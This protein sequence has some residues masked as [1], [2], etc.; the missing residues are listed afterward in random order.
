MK[1]LTIPSP[2]P[3]TRRST[4]TGRCLDCKNAQYRRDAAKVRAKAQAKRAVRTEADAQRERELRHERWIKYEKA[5]SPDQAQRRRIAARAEA[6]RLF[7]EYN[8]N[9]S[10]T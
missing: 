1:K 4:S 6:R 8:D 10:R 3:H 7:K 9:R 2:C 5:K